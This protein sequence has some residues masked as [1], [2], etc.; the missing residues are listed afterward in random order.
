MA[1]ISVARPE[2]QIELEDPLDHLPFSNPLEYRKGRMIYSQEQP[3]TSLYLVVE[4]K[5]KVSRLADDGHQ[6]VLDIY[7][8]DDFFGES[9]FL[10]LP[11]RREQA[12]ALASIVEGEARVDS[13]RETIAGVYENRL[14]IGMALQADPT[15][16]YAIELKTGKP[17]P[18]LFEKDYL[19]PSPYNTYLNPGLP[20][21]PISSPGLRSIEATIY[22]ASVPFLY[23]VAGADGHHIFSRTY[24]EHLRAVA[25]SRRARGR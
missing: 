17:K 6:V 14:R 11:R 7:Q 23:F 25:E 2:L 9:A 3:S 10:N 13:E 19:T 8:A 1:T 4:G 12:V 5:V 16:Q 15:V 21:G 24:A 22:A 20:P 18:R